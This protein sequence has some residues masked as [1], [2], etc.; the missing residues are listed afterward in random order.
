MCLTAFTIAVLLATHVCSRV[1]AYPGIYSPAGRWSHAK[2]PDLVCGK[3]FMCTP[4]NLTWVS[5]DKTDVLYDA[6]SGCDALIN[7]GITRIDFHGDSY[8]RQ[9]YAAILITLNGNYVNGSIADTPYAKK[10]G[11]HECTYQKQFAEKFCGIRSLNHGPVVCGGKVILDPLL[12]GLETLKQCKGGGKSTGIA[13]FSW[14]NYKVGPQ[15][16]DRH[17]VN[18]ATAYG[19]FFEDTKLCPNIRNYDNI[20]LATHTMKK[21]SC[22]I[23]WLS[24]HYRL[25]HH[26]DDE[27]VHVVKNYNEKMRDWAVSGTCGMLNYV[28]VYNMTAALGKEHK[29]EAQ[30]MSSIPLTNSPRAVHWGMEV[31]LV[32]AQ[33]IL[34]A[35]IRTVNARKSAGPDGR[36]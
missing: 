27:H 25:M 4:S 3:Q 32:K 31:N 6:Q 2:D 8:M 16:F 26:F 19:R 24:T 13:L 9:I 21:R 7:A 36:I 23:F 18:N 17:G 35:L 1:H 10:N 29:A 11:A 33:M 20:T 12:N 30:H 14:G 22:D 5:E 15:I 28:D 34:N